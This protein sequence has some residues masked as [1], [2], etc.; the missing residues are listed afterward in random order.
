MKTKNQKKKKRERE[1]KK[2]KHK[3]SLKTAYLKKY[4]EFFVQ[5]EYASID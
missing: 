3:K 5:S 4:P 2:L 1:L